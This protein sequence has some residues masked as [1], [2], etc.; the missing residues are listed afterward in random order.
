MLLWA[1]NEQQGISNFSDKIFAAHV[2]EAARTRHAYRDEDV[3]WYE[4]FALWLNSTAA[5][6][7]ANCINRDI[8]N[9]NL[10][11]R[12]PPFPVLGALPPHELTRVSLIEKE[13]IILGDSFI[14]PQ[15]YKASLC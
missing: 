9:D 6:F 2:A 4:E 8:S 14:L 13:S 5:L 3:A 1:P 12:A 15:G 10:C 11:S 7:W